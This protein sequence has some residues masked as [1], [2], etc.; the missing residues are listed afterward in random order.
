MSWVGRAEHWQSTM[1]EPPKSRSPARS[2]Q[3][4]RGQKQKGTGEGNL[5][6]LPDPRQSKLYIDKFGHL[7]TASVLTN[8]SETA[9]RV[10]G[11]RKR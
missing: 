6:S 7:H 10:M 2:R 1:R 4:G 5:T 3:A 9:Q 8:W 11:I